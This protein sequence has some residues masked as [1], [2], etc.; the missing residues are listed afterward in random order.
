MSCAPHPLLSCARHSISSCAI[1]SP[2]FSVWERGR[3]TGVHPLVD[4]GTHV[5]LGVSESGNVCICCACAQCEVLRMR[6]R[7]VS[8]GVVL[9]QQCH[10]ATRA[11]L[12]TV[13]Q[14]SQVEF[15][16]VVF[17]SLQ[18]LQVPGSTHKFA[19]CSCNDAHRRR[20]NR[21]M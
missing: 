10:C 6:S 7:D 9:T 16:G 2:G 4:P 14:A 12:I 20:L 5:G 1:N 17:W 8:C 15:Y 13:N 19:S 18:G 3:V 21:I 11:R